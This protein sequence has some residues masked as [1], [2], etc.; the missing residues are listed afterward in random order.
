MRSFFL[1]LWQR[2]IL[3]CLLLFLKK[4]DSLQAFPLLLKLNR[5]LLYLLL[6]NPGSL[7]SGLL[8]LKPQGF[9]ALLFLLQPDSLPNRL[10]LLSLKRRLLF[11]IQNLNSFL[12]SFFLRLL[13]PG[14]R[15]RLDGLTALLLCQLLPH[16]IL[17]LLCQSLLKI[18]G[19]KLV[20]VDL[21]HL[22][23]LCLLFRYHLAVLLLL[24]SSQRL[25]THL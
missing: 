22:N 12:P 11:L 1:R 5:L 6:L 15:N 9:L 19:V 23:L 17:K 4:P 18:A 24:G 2:R 13:T 20:H 7:L 14:R 21:L 3:P 10:F 25:N 16:K 8:A